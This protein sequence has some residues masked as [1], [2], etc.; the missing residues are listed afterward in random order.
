VAYVVGLNS[1]TAF[2]RAFDKATGMT[3]QKYDEMLVNS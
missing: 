1:K 2:Y 3:P